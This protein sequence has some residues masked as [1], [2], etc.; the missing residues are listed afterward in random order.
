[1]EKPT[2]RRRVQREGMRVHGLIALRYE[3]LPTAAAVAYKNQ[4]TTF[5]DNGDDNEDNETTTAPT[6]LNN[7][8]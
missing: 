3:T 5:A 2:R 7:V 8:C 1:M 4:R 6:Q